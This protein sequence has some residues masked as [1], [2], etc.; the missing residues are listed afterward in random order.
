MVALTNRLLEICCA[1]YLLF[2]GENEKD[3]RDL[4][5]T[6]ASFPEGHILP[7][8]D[9]CMTLY[10][11]C[12]AKTFSFQDLLDLDKCIFDISIGIDNFF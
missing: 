8:M 6:S 11:L 1:P 4:L 3:S 9:S 7:V 12:S 10:W 2:E 5:E